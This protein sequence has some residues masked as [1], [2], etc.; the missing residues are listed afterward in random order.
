[1]GNKNDD[2]KTVT[3]RYLHL[4]NV[5]RKNDPIEEVMCQ[6]IGEREYE[7]RADY[8]ADDKKLRAEITALR[9]ELDA[10]KQKLR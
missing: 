5:E 4:R 7:I 3:N 10:L 8:I 6:V 1:M 9:A 2:I